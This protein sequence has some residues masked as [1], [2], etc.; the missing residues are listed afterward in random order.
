MKKKEEERRKG[1]A[2]SAILFPL[3]IRVLCYAG[4]TLPR[5]VQLSAQHVYRAQV[6]FD[7]S[8]TSASALAA[9]VEDC[10][11]EA[12]VVYVTPPASTRQVIVGSA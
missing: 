4:V 6:K 3:H 1:V 5:A 9:A 8:L 10:G 12:T 11:F 2:Q 7:E